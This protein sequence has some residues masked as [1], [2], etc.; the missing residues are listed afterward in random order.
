V[1][2]NLIHNNGLNAI[3]NNH[4]R[5]HGAMLGILGQLQNHGGIFRKNTIA[6]LAN[7]NAGQASPNTAPEVNGLVL[8]HGNWEVSNN[9]ISLRN[10]TTGTHIDFR[11]TFVIGIRDHLRNLAG[12]GANYLYNSVYIY[13]V[14]GG[15][16]A[17]NPSYNYLRIPNN[18]GNVAGAPTVLRNNILIN[19]RSGIGSHRAIGNIN[20]GSPATGWNTAAS[21]FNFVATATASTATRWGTTDYTFANWRTITGGDANSIYV[22]TAAS[23]I[24]NVQLLPTELFESDFL[25]GN[26]RISGANT[27]ASDFID[28]NAT[29]LLAVI[30]DIDGDLRDP[31]TPDIGADEFNV[32]S[33]PQ[34]T[35]QPVD[36][37]NICNNGNVVFNATIFGQAPINLQWQ[38]STDGGSTWNDLSN[39][40]IYSGVNTNTLTLTGV[41]SS[42]N[43][44][45]YRLLADNVCGSNTSDEVEL[46]ITPLPQITAYSPLTF[47]NSICSGNTSFSVTATGVGLTYQW[48]ESVDGGSSWNDVSNVAPYS[49]ATTSTLQ[50]SNIPPPNLNGNKYRLIITD[51]CGEVLTSDEGTLIIG[52]AFVDAQPIVEQTVCSGSVVNIDVDASGLGL[53]FQWQF[54]SDN[55]ST[56]NN[57]TTPT[58]SGSNTDNLSFTASSAL[59]GYLYRV[60][61][62]SSV[63]PGATTSDASLLN[64]EFPGQWLGAGTDWDT[65]SNWGCGIV[66]TTTTDVLIPTN[67]IFGD[68]FPVVSSASLS[69]ARDL[70]IQPGASVTVQS[71]S[72]LSLHGNFTNNGFNGMGTGAVRF[73][74][75]SLQVIDGTAQTEFGAI[76]LN[77]STTIQ[78]ALELN[79]HISVLGAISMLQG[80]LHL[81]GSDIDLLGT[82]S[83]VNESNANRIYG[84]LGEIKTV[85]NMAANTTYN[86]IF[87]MGVSIITGVT[88]PGLTVI[89]R[90]HFQHSH[91]GSYQSIQRY[92]D[93]NP[94]VNAS[95]DATLRINYFDDELDVTFGP[96]PVKANL[97]PWRSTDNGATWEGQFFPSNLTNDIVNNWVQ[98]TSIPAFSRWTLSDWVN[99]PL[100][101]QLLSF[102]A[103]ADYSNQQVDLQWLTASE[104]NNAFFTVERS[105]DAQSFQPVLSRPGAGNSNTVITYNDVDPNPLMGIS[106]YRLKQTDFDGST[107]YSDVVPV[108]FQQQVQASANV[109]AAEAGNIYL[110]Y[111]GLKRG[112]LDVNIYDAGGRLIGNYQFNAAQGSNQFL[113]S[114]LDLATGVYIIRINDGVNVF[115]NKLM[116]KT[117]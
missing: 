48:Q 44:N 115:S 12:Q 1:E 20:T 58:Y 111:F 112:R 17:G 67:P 23:T 75:N 21:D 97:L 19:E 39:A 56:W 74:G 100:P 9:M 10:G 85:L 50:F 72:N 5:N 53:T 81:N 107:T 77:N 34:F 73:V 45:Q 7:S 3:V 103:T 40:G 18:A 43:N 95:L 26:L 113:I 94:V 91:M 84:D 99:N 61:I 116:L 8:N 49:G 62:N 90:G 13:G 70:S 15:S 66:P 68:V 96:P 16:G 24:A 25:F 46:T 31:F 92:F 64:V 88:A 110:Q 38:E 101:V 63:C 104:I 37:L 79:Q 114:D 52:V 30:D 29:P 4:V 54:S 11:N 93:I 57:A 82:G 109:Y 69:V 78:P 83:I 117:R 27:D 14:N 71:A 80:R 108:N 2:G 60:I 35:L 33:S 36:Q 51:A 28:N 76:D 102:T 42:L 41:T 86:D 89:E 59:N 6:A 22:P 47:I 65:P 105:A 55:G 106:Y 87:G 98:L 32:C